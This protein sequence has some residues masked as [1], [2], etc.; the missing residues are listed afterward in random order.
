MLRPNTGEY[1]AIQP[2]KPNDRTV[3]LQF[4]GDQAKG[5]NATL[6]N[7]PHYVDE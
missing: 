3:S 2:M 5:N 7:L 1:K 4:E 6:F